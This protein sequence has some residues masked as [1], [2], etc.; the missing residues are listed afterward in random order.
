[1]FSRS[2]FQRGFISISALIYML[3]LPSD[4]IQPFISFSMAV[5]MKINSAKKD[6]CI[7]VFYFELIS[8][9]TQKGFS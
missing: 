9:G 3:H 4:L 1:M 5:N 8:E 7:I 6:Y 2:K